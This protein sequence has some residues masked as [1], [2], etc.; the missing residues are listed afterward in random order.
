MA[1]DASN[2]LAPIRDAVAA[3]LSGVPVPRIVDAGCGSAMHIPIPDSSVVVGVDIS[4]TQLDRNAG[5]SERICADLQTVDLRGMDADLVVVWDVME[6]IR[7][8]SDAL[9]RLAAA[10]RPGGLLLVAG[11]N[12]MS[13]KGLTTKLTPHW[14]HVWFYRTVYGIQT[15]GQADTRPFR[16]Y[17]RL[18]MS[19]GGI[20]R[21]ARETA[22]EVVY[23][24]RYE[25]ETQARLVTRYRVFGLLY[26]SVGAV[27]RV[28]SLGRVTYRGTEF[29]AL[30]RL[31]FA[32]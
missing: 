9:D 30:L 12:P 31:P 1:M 21:W 28:L 16:T 25:G 32:S 2:E 10:L 5:L 29:A 15:A 22:L 14:F 19:P 20:E 8:P 27:A 11:P 26:R 6:H 7:R 4:K 18:A 23:V 24:V 13:L 3:A 17:M